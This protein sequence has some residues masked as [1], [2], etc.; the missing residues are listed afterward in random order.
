M[1]EG[2]VMGELTHEQK[3]AV[4]RRIYERNKAKGGFRLT[5][6]LTSLS[7]LAVAACG[8]VG[9]GTM[10]YMLWSVVTSL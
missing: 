8:V 4:H 6:A 9:V 7:V 5:N 2:G 1:I 3:C 10:V